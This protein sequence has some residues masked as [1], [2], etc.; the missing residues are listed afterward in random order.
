MLL[1]KPPLSSI[2]KEAK[3]VMNNKLAIL[4]MNLVLKIAFTCLNSLLPDYRL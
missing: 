2:I 4:D 1:E 3:P